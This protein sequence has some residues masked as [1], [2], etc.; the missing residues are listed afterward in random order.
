[1]LNIESLFVMTVTRPLN[2]IDLGDTLY[3]VVCVNGTPWCQPYRKG[4]EEG[5]RGRRIVERWA[6]FFYMNILREVRIILIFDLLQAK[7]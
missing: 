6:I 7:Q 5:W 2:C 4:D 3:F 1:M